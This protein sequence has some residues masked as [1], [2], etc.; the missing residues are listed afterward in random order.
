MCGFVQRGEELRLAPEAG[1]TLRILTE[2]VGDD[3]DRDLEP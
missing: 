1:Q 2:A 3:L